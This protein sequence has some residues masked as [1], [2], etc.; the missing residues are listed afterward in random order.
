MSTKPPKKM[1]TKYLIPMLL[2]LSVGAAAQTSKK[3][4]YKDLNIAGGNYYAYPGPSQKVLTPA[5]EGYKPFY[6]SHYGR[7]GSRYMTDN[8]P[9]IYAID[10]LDSAARLGILTPKGAGVLEKLR[11]GYADAYNRDGD[12]SKLGRVQ[13][14]EIAQRMYARFPEL[15]SQPAK[16]DARSSTE[17]RCIIS[18]FYFCQELQGLNPSMD[19]HMDASKRDMPF[20]VED[21]HVEPEE[22]PAMPALERRIDA[23]MEKV[24]DPSRFMK[25]MFT[26]VR[27]AESF[28][29]GMELMDA[30]YDISSDLQNVPELGISLTDIFTKEEMFNVFR[31]FNSAVMLSLGLVPG[32]TPVYQAQT[33]IR[34]SIVTFADRAISAG[35]PALDLRFGHDAS[36]LPLAYLMG[37]KEAMGGSTDLENMYK[38]ISI[39]KLIPMAANVQMVFYRKDGSDDVLV[40][41]LYNENETSIPAVKTD[42]APYYHW[43][44]VK[45]YWEGRR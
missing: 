38:T 8:T 19:I 12:L 36:I 45:R 39:D 30:L 1:K 7:H 43:A 41:F 28:V 27:K 14:R 6:I 26:D 3:E 44:D 21:T 34:D 32:S 37:V 18:M 22:T 20:I 5:P 29:D 15:L 31:V 23:M 24:A 35:G 9:Y 13:H 11:I 2:L 10:Q 4:V 33:A 25:S 17:G 40:K 42:V 16:V